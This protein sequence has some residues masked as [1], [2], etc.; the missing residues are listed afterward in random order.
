MGSSG[1]AT[2]GSRARQTRTWALSKQT[3]I[4]QRCTSFTAGAGHG[5]YVKH[6]TCCF[7]KSLVS[8]L[9]F[10]FPLSNSHTLCLNFTIHKKGTAGGTDLAIPVSK[11]LPT[12]R[13]L[14]SLLPSETN[15]TQILPSQV[16]VS[17]E[18]TPSLSTPGICTP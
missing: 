2:S 14:P 10:P 11:Q 7:F 5:T 8:S 1:G 12:L 3:T 15:A 17:C 16:K 6:A 18:T 9:T 4:L 13:C